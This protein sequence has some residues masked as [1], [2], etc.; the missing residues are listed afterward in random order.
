MTRKRVLWAV[1]LFFVLQLYFI[2][3]LLAAELLFGV[4]FGIVFTIIAAFYIVGTIGE[5]SL[6]WTEAGVRVVAQSARRGY[7]SVEELSKR[8]FRRPHSESAR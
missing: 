5:R 7:T 8:P 6:G 2:R 3:E 1:A 4:V